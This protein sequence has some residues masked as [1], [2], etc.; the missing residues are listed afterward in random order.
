MNWFVTQ[1]QSEAL[2]QKQLQ[3]EK[4][5][6]EDKRKEELLALPLRDR[7]LKQAQTTLDDRRR[8][9]QKAINITNVD[10]TALQKSK[11]H[12]LSARELSE[13]MLKALQTIDTKLQN[14]LTLQADKVEAQQQAKIKAQLEAQSLQNETDKVN[15]Q[16]AILKAQQHKAIKKKIETQQAH[17]KSIAEQKGYQLRKDLA[18]AEQSQRQQ[19]TLQAEESLRLIKDKSSLKDD[20]QHKTLKE[21]KK[22]IKQSNNTLKAKTKK[23]QLKT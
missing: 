17:K 5:A 23:A 8:A 13:N 2:H 6:Q 19:E 16:V 10:E 7:T 1:Q 15:T 12:T 9:L 18:K 14:K 21:I 11:E 20:T 22:G 4:K 3:K